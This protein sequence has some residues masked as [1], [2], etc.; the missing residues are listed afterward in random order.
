MYLLMGPICKEFRYELTSGHYHN[1]GYESR[2]LG[3]ESRVSELR[4]NRCMI[5]IPLFLL[6][7]LTGPFGLIVSIHIS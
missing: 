4:E 5:T 1:Q 2:I 3:F 6:K 7:I